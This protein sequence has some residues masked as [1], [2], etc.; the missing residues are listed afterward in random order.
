MDVME[1]IQKI[2]ETEKLIRRLIELEPTINIV[3]DASP[4]VFIVP[5]ILDETSTAIPE[6][7]GVLEYQVSNG[8]A[9]ERS[10]SHDVYSFEDAKE[11]A[12]TM[13]DK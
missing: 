6:N 7:V 10:I 12:K 9:G 13:G 5:V 2:N 3:M 1:K 4:N 8:V 11:E